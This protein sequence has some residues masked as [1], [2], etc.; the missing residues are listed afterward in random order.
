MYL[1]DFLFFFVNC[2][3]VWVKWTILELP[4]FL[5][6]SYEDNFFK[7]MNKKKQS[8]KI[9]NMNNFVFMKHNSILLYIITFEKRILLACYILLS[10]LLQYFY[11]ILFIGVNIKLL[12][13][14]WKTEKHNLSVIH[15]V[16]SES[17]V[18]DS[19]GSLAMYWRPLSK[20]FSTTGR[21]SSSCLL[22]PRWSSC[23]GDA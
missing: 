15:N 5:I 12:A 1:A 16:P 11:K 18:S 20:L 21:L 14:N 7:N 22:K 4:S 3:F 10:S 13:A 23:K 19:G 2:S 17:D 6:T 8:S 9:I